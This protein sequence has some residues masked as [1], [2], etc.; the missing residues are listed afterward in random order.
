MNK[1]EKF[2]RKTYDNYME[3]LISREEYVKYMSEYESEIK[4][5]Q[6]KQEKI[7]NK[8]DIQQELNAQYDEWTEAFR[9]YIH[10]EKLTREVVLELIDKIEIEADN[11]ITIYYK[12][13][14]PYAD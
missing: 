11:S 13:H 4:E 1:L 5:L 9:N 10:I 7:Q 8:S 6:A 14:N 3:D 2:K 12:F